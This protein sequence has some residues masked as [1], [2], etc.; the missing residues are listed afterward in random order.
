MTRADLDRGADRRWF[1]RG[2]TRALL[3]AGV[4]VG[5]GAVGFAARQHVQRDVIGVVDAE[6]G[7]SI[8]KWRER[9]ALAQ[10]VVKLVAEAANL[11]IFHGTESVRAVKGN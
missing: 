6:F 2:R 9:L 3:S 1:G 11:G 8:G 7:M 5:F 4:L 10:G